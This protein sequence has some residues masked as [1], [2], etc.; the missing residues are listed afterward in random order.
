V[1]ADHPDVLVIGALA[2]RDG[3]PGVTR[4]AMQGMV[5]VAACI[6]RDLGTGGR[7]LP[8]PRTRIGGVHQLWHAVPPAAFGV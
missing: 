5:P 6:R 4:N 2:G 8:L 7:R 1:N 3:L